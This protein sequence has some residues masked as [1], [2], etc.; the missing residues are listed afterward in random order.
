MVLLELHQHSDFGGQLSLGIL[1]ALW[2]RLLKRLRKAYAS[3]GASDPESVSIQRIARDE[4]HVEVDCPKA[5]FPH[6]DKRSRWRKVFATG[7][8]GVCLTHGR[9]RRHAE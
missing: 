5:L 8:M 9:V 4:V 3:V 7:R 1:W 6:T 2:S